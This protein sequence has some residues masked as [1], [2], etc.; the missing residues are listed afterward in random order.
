MH[1]W[2]PALPLRALTELVPAWREVL[3]GAR[4]APPEGDADAII[5]LGA[6]VLPDG[7]PSASLRARVEGAAQLW[8]AGRAPLI[9]TTGA[10]HLRPPGEAVVARALLVALGVPPEAIVME[11]KSRNTWGNL[12]YARAALP[13]AIHRVWI[14]TEPFHMGRAVRF[15][16]AA[17]FEPL[18]WP[19]VS[20]AW[21]RPA[22]RAR[23]LARDALSLAFHRAGA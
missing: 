19:V 11:E 21:S 9:C 8:R 1:R 18:P 12:G 6:A 7:G 5:V 2:D 3:A 22:S 13:P 4:L 15:A 10:S 23:W 16:R 14:V 17:G 20:P